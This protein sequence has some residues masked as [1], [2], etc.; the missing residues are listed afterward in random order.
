MIILITGDS[1][2]GKNK[3]QKQSVCTK[4]FRIANDGKLY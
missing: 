2:T 1:H 3:L 4:F